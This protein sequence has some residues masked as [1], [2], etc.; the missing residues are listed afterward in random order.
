MSTS[1]SFAI[2]NQQMHSLA[3]IASS[4]QQFLACIGVIGA[5]VAIEQAIKCA[6]YLQATIV[7]NRLQKTLERYAI[8]DVVQCPIE[9]PLQKR[10][11]LDNRIAEASVAAMATLGVLTIIGMIVFTTLEK[12]YIFTGILAVVLAIVTVV[13]GALYEV[14][15]CL[16]KQAAIILPASGENENLSDA[17]SVLTDVSIAVSQIEK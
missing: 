16:W 6:P 14:P 9:D 13:I 8:Q 2:P 12:L 5:I 10:D 7:E 1:L 17:D 3:R 4:N 11:D 15:K